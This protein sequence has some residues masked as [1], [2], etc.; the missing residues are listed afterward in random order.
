MA[1]S[2]WFRQEQ[3]PWKFEQRYK[4]PVIGRYQSIHLVSFAINLS[5]HLVIGHEVV[6]CLV[7]R[8]LRRKGGPACGARF[9]G[10]FCAGG[11]IAGTAA[12]HLKREKWL[13]RRAGR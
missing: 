13:Q 1:L 8:R 2:S 7:N 12:R 5:S 11:G 4:I 9:I 6:Y 3:R 10:A